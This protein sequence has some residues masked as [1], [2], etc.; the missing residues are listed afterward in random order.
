MSDFFKF[1]DKSLD[2]P[3]YNGIPQLSTKDWIILLIGGILEI[4]LIIGI[5]YL[6]PGSEYLPDE[7]MPVLFLLVLLIPIAYVCKG[8]L[9]LLFK[10]PKLND[11]KVIVICYIIYT[12]FSIAM[13]YLFI[14]LGLN[15]VAN[16]TEIANQS[17]ALSIIL[18]IIQ[19]LGEE[20]FKFTVFILPMALTFKLTQ[21]RKTSMII[22]IIVSSIIFGLVHL[23]AYN[24]NIL[25]C[26]AIIGL[27][28]VISTYPYYKSK[29][30]ANTYILHLMI[31]L[32]PTLLIILGL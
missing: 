10:K 4:F 14:R 17:D 29:N 9:G 25:Q 2:F 8:N 24:G 6:I 13:A 15:A 20:L 12:I 3:F 28:N 23:G 31:D 16:T 7:I 26:L 22:G 18:M 21:N 30:I 32:I 1:E 5:I 27:G 19:L 11:I